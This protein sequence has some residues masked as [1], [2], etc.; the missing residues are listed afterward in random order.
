MRNN[1]KS[2]S[3]FKKKTGKNSGN[4]VRVEA[5]DWKSARRRRSLACKHGIYPSRPFRLSVALYYEKEKKKLM[6]DIPSSLLLC[7]DENSPGMA[8]HVE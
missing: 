2:S 3:T 4:A 8:E 6:D 5:F 1:E 7:A